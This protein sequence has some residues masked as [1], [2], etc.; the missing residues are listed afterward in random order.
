MDQGTRSVSLSKF[1][2]TRKI[3]GVM[4]EV[5]I[6]HARGTIIA[7]GK[8]R[9]QVH[10]IY[11]ILE[12]AAIAAANHWME[13][14][15]LPPRR[16][17][18]YD[19]GK[20]A[21][22]YKDKM[23]REYF[24]ARIG[25]REPMV[26]NGRERQV[27]RYYQWGHFGTMEEATAAAEEFKRTGNRSMAKDGQVGG[28]ML[29]TKADGTRQFSV[30]AEEVEA[31]KSRRR[32]IDNAKRAARHK[33]AIESGRSPRCPQDVPRTKTPEVQK[34][35]AERPKTKRLLCDQEDELRERIRG[36]VKNPDR[37]R[38]A[39]FVSIRASE[40]GLVEQFLALHKLTLFKVETTGNF[41]RIETK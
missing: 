38:T 6:H 27:R 37:G 40:S 32:D 21:L 33:R 25:R 20:C 12:S 13:T 1:T 36:L 15:E 16:Q 19:G 26:V 10:I 17:S 11:S 14:G 9:K 22:K 4:Q 29:V 7:P 8:N 39:D 23:G 35:A 31:E 3:N 5:T 28:A 18:M 34:E 41:L 2:D 30:N 24:K